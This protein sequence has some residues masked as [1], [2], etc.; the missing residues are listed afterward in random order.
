[1]KNETSDKIEKKRLTILG[2]L[3]EAKEPLGSLKIMELMNH[4]RY[5][6]R[7]RTV[8][9]HLQ[10]MDET[11]L[12]ECVGRRGHRITPQGL[13]ELSQARAFE[14]LGFLNA[15]IDELSFIM[16][17]DLA[18][19]EGTVV[20]NMS[21]I[22]QRD[23]LLSYAHMLEVFKRG[24]GMG[25]LMAIFG[26]GESVGDMTVPDGMVG[27]GT[28]C[29]ITVNG[30]LVSHGIPV[31]SRFGGLLEYRGGKP[32][33]FTSLINYDGT[34]LDPLEIF[35]KSGMTEHGGVLRSGIGRVGAGF[36]EVPS[37]SREKVMDLV[38]DL[39]EADLGG[40]LEVGFPGRD[41]FEVPINEGRIGAIVIGG[42]NPVAILEEQ[43]IKVHSRAL[44]SLID[45]KNLFHYNTFEERF[46]ELIKQTS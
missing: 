24:F 28:V 16:S 22:G 32:I 42:L 30:V 9:F 23:L 11:G 34:T 15:R 39:K 26:P 10:A 2:I 5:D 36:R 37:S 6:I 29:S 41:L 25:N 31:V 4:M 21:L 3:K 13:L 18:R 14:K 38:S 33:R 8:R 1:M 44:C 35:I 27:V 46:R 45:Y 19:R 7:E 40:I 43:G 12:T 20:I 17:F